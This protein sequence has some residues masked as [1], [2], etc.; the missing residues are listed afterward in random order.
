MHGTIR[1]KDLMSLFLAKHQGVSRVRFHTPAPYE[2]ITTVY[3]V[4]VKAESQKVTSHA[5]FV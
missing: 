4:L 2:N 1:I 5:F 3:T